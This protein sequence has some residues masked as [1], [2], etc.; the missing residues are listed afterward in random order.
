M[1]KVWKRIP[2]LAKK[3]TVRAALGSGRFVASDTTDPSS[4]KPDI[5]AYNLD[6]GGQNA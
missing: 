2:G 6:S 1:L 3:Y 4:L 5:Y